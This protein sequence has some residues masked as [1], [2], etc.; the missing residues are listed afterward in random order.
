[1]KPKAL[2]VTPDT[3]KRFKDYCKN[4]GIKTQHLADRII[5]EWLEKQKESKP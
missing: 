4:E 1:M 5:R 2:L 3:H